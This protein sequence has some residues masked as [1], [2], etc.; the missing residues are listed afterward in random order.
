MKKY[1]HLLIQKYSIFVGAGFFAVTIFEF[2][3]VNFF[4]IYPIISIITLV[5]ERVTKEKIINALELSYQEISL[6]EKPDA[7]LFDIE[8]DNS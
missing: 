6:L 2:S 1:F 3:A 5:S 7:F 4:L 8:Y